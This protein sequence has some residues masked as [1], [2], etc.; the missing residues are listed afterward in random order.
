MSGK[1]NTIDVLI[2][3]NFPLVHS[4]LFQFFNQEFEN[5]EP[6]KACSIKEVFHRINEKPSFDLVIIGE[7]LRG[8]EIGELTGQVHQLI[9]TSNILILADQFDYEKVVRYVSNGATGYITKRSELSEI[10]EALRAQ[11]N[12]EPF[13]SIEVLMAFAQ[14]KIL[15]LRAVREF[16]PT[17]KELEIDLPVS[18]LS[19]KE[20]EI[21]TYLLHGESTTGISKKL[22]LSPST[23]SAHKS[24]ILRKLGV[25]ST[26]SLIKLLRIKQNMS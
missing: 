6:A 16:Y 11:L 5:I 3:D 2:A 12:N 22:N 21:L 1:M 8:G 19:K 15:S 24:V 17:P 18:K 14:E 7:N 4:S 10:K 26:V 23:V 25:T 20:T 9:P 13:F